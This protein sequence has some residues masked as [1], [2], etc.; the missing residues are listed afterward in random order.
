MVGAFAPM[1]GGGPLLSQPPDEIPPRRNLERTFFLSSR[2]L[3]RD[4]GE[5]GCARIRIGMK[6]SSDSRLSG[7][8]KKN[9]PAF[10]HLLSAMSCQLSTFS[11]FPLNF[12]PN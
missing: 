4:P 2:P 6:Q 5:D 1:T 7:K 12:L 11:F 8:D 10:F 9:K 3:S